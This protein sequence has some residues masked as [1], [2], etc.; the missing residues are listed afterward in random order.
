MAHAFD[1]R[2]GTGCFGSFAAERFGGFVFFRLGNAFV[3]RFAVFFYVIDAETSL[4]V[5]HIGRHLIGNSWKK[6]IKLVG[7]D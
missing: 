4:I 7:Q 5:K 1:G 3:A 2:F 6:G